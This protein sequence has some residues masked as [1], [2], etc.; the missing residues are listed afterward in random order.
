MSNEKLLNLKKSSYI[1]T[2]I[3]EFLKDEPIFTGLDPGKIDELESKLFVFL[4][5]VKEWIQFTAA[6]QRGQMC[7]GK[8][9]SAI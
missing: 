8:G 3:K 4:Q 9:G 7:S 1:S 2:C 6:R 5:K